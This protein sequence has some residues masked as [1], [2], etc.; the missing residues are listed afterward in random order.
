MRLFRLA[1]DAALS[2]FAGRRALH[3]Y[4]FFGD[5]VWM[6]GARA[7]GT[8]PPA[9]NG[10][11]S[12]RPEHESGPSS[13]LA[14]VAGRDRGAAVAPMGGVGMIVL[15]ARY[16]AKPGAGDRVEAA[17]REMIPLARQEEGCLLYYAS[18][19][20]DDPDQFLLYEHYAS[21][22][23]L[24]AHRETPHYKRII[25]GTILPLLERRERQLFRLVDP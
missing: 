8:A 12:W 17:L 6:A 10:A 23:F 5:P 15:V 19:S 9:R 2:A 14:G 1:W 25:E 21:E 16:Y 22:A 20:Q 11:G 18:R 7:A 24:A 13:T 3:E 4:L